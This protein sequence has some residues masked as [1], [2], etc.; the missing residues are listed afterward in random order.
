MY[1]F[2][3]Q[4][5]SEMMREAWNAWFFK[6]GRMKRL[7]FACMILL[8][9]IAIEAGR[10]RFGTMS[11]V[12]VTILTFTVLIYA[13]AYFVG[14]RRALEKR[15]AIVDGK[16]SYTLTDDTIEVRSSLGSVALA[17]SAISEVRRHRDLVLLGFR[18][19]AYSTI[20]S[21]QIPADALSY[22]VERAKANGAQIIRF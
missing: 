19:A 17:W 1:K 8:A 22:L 12:S 13:T 5:E 14:L 3:V 7:A 18:G 11:V 4:I 16:A 6:A 20:P 2:D 15:E 10:G 21:T 9:S